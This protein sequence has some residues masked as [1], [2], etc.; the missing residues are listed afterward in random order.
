MIKTIG[1]ILSFFVVVIVPPPYK[2][3]RPVIKNH[4]AQYSPSPTRSSFSSKITS[5]ARD[6]FA[7]VRLRI[8]AGGGNLNERTIYGMSKANERKS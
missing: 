1:F 3:N 6:K 5:L 7:G 2:K 8:Y 4:G